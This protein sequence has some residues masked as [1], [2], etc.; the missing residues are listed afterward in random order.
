M[1]SLYELK[2]LAIGEELLLYRRSPK[3]CCTKVHVYDGY[4]NEIVLSEDNVKTM[5]FPFSTYGKTWY[6]ERFE[7]E[8]PK[9]SKD[10]IFLALSK[11]Q[12]GIFI[13][14][15]IKSHYYPSTYAAEN[16]DS[17]IYELPELKD[18]DQVGC[19]IYIGK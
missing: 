16:P 18:K 3:T 2:N 9:V 8:K 12:E 6:L 17:K 14:A 15:V 13:E 5:T 4:D 10:R 7:Q 1:I 19:H 11:D